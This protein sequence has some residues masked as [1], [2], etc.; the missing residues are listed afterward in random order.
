MRAVERGPWR[1]GDE[2]LPVDGEAAVGSSSRSEKTTTC[3][4]IVVQRAAPHR[5][6]EREFSRQTQKCEIVR[7]EAIIELTE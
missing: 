1:G 6:D 4:L 3:L 5:C 2:K 7:R